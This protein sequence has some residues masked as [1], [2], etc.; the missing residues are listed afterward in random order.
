MSS[1]NIKVLLK[2]FQKLATG[3][4]GEE[5]PQ[6]RNAKRSPQK[7]EQTERADHPVD[8]P[9]ERFCGPPGG[10][11]VITGKPFYGKAPSRK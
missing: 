6:K 9:P 4:G 3:C 5:P 8:G 1:K 2:L 11:A 10:A 7:G